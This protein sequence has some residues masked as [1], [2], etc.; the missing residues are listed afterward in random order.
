MKII[1]GLGNPGKK[2]ESTYHNLGFRSIDKCA[3]KIGAAFC[4]EKFSGVIAECRV[5]TEKV[6]LLKPATYMN[7]SGI[8]VREVMSFYKADLSDLMV[9]YDDFDLPAGTVRIRK[10]G[11]AGTHNGMRSVIQELGR[12]DF[13]RVRVGFNTP[14]AESIPLI[15]F[16]LSDIA[17]EYV[18]TLEKATDIAGEAGYLF[19][20]GVP[21]DEIMQKL[22]G[23]SLI[24]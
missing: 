24:K 16:V 21:V 12:E 18:K 8:S 9:I 4:T 19:A 7:L 22:N 1:V 15:D 17:G 2:Y 20:K 3:E 5:G 14:L 23:N 13:V 6:V 11:S 10:N